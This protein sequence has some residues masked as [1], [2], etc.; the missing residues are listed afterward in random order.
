MPSRSHPDLLMRYD[1]M[2]DR[3]SHPNTH[4]SEL[5]KYKRIK[6][7]NHSELGLLVKEFSPLDLSH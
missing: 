3:E 4:F 6:Q 2:N 7:L 5:S 1:F